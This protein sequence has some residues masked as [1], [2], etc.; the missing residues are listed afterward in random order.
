MNILEETLKE[1]SKT[2]RNL[3]IDYVNGRAEVFAE[4]M[5]LFMGND[6]RV[7]QRLSWVVSGCIEKWTYLAD[8]YLPKMIKK[9]LE[10]N[11]H[12]AYKRNT[13]RALLYVDIPENLHG[14]LAE[15]CFR[16][17]GNLNEAVAIKFFAMQMLEKLVKIYP[18]LKEELVM[19]L[20]EQMPY[21]SS[22]FKSK[23]KKILKNLGR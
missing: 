23:G 2:Q 5:T 18:E 8:D 9:L 10:P 17:L 1:H 3:I 14:E 7:T 13:I 11:L 6:Y 16:F 12:D 4:V 21:E 22:A 15:A 20:E 19:H